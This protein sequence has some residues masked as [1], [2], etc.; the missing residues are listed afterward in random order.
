MKDE[1][2]VVNEVPP[3]LNAICFIS[4][5]CGSNMEEHIECAK[6]LEQPQNYE[7]LQLLQQ[8]AEKLTK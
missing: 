3:V 5:F 6:L 4:A 2:P 8:L 1:V 7:A